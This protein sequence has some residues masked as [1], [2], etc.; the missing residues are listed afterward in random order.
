MSHKYFI[1]IDTISLPNLSAL[2]MIAQFPEW[3]RFFDDARQALAFIH[4]MRLTHEIEVY[5]SKTNLFERTR[6]RESDPDQ[7][8]LQILDK[9]PGVHRVRVFYDT[10]NDLT[11]EQQLHNSNIYPRRLM[12]SGCMINDLAFQICL[13]G[14]A[15]L[16]QEISR[17]IEQSENHLVSHIESHQEDLDK[18]SKELIAQRKLE[19]T[20]PLERHEE[21]P[22][23]E[24]L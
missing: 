5:S 7:T 14:I 13:H 12:G 19:A 9:I 1:V 11:K 24:T 6:E 15:Y 21:K 3:L 23:E 22:S 4:V 17:C 8:L 10:R 20:Q 18:Y 16:N 2:R